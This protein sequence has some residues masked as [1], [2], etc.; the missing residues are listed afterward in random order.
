MKSAL[1]IF[2]AGI[3]W[4]LIILIAVATVRTWEARGDDLPL[5]VDAA[6]IVCNPTLPAR[7]RHSRERMLT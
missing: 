5:L 7:I 2:A 4:L 1:V 3:A 6:T